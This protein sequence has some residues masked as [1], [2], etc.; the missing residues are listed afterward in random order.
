MELI[1]K[2]YD[3]LLIGSM[4]VLA[5]LIIFSA[6]RELRIGSLRSI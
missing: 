4:L 5:V 6:V 1:Q 3:A 2:A